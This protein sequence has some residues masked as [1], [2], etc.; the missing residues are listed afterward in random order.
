MKLMRR[1]QR[2]EARAAVISLP[3]LAAVFVAL[4]VLSQASRAQS[5]K[6]AGKPA[7]PQ[8]P[9][10]QTAAMRAGPMTGEPTGI[11]VSRDTH[12]NVGPSRFEVAS[13]TVRRGWPGHGPE[14]QSA[15]VPGDPEDRRVGYHSDSGRD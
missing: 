9:V 14:R 13:P 15:G 4:T 5:G 1:E 12:A 10:T 11:P 3:H 7:P 6:P 2:A 8:A